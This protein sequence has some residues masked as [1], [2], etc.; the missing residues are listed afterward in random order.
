[1]YVISHKCL[2]QKELFSSKNLT[3]THQGKH[4]MVRALLPCNWGTTQESQQLIYFGSSMTTGYHSIFSGQKKE[5]WSTAAHKG[6]PEGDWIGWSYSPTM[7]NSANTCETVLSTRVSRN[8][9]KS[10]RNSQKTSLGGFDLKGC[11]TAQYQK[12]KQPNP[13][14]GRRPKWTF[15]QR[16]DTDGQE[17]HER[18]LNIT[19]H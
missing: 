17:A 6:S 16:R 19:N 2:S 14:K 3:Y 10:K 4:F 13:K 5:G 11:R 8:S 1:M 7:P 15:L 12:N 18:M 9:Q